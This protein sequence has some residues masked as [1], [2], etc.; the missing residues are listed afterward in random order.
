MFIKRLVLRNI[1]SYSKAEIF[2][3][4]GITLLSGDIGS[5][6]T[7]ILIAL[8]FALFGIL[9]GKTSPAELLRHGSTEGSVSLECELAGK[10]V[11]I[12]RE[13]K[14]RG[15]S[16]LQVPGKLL[17][18]GFE[19]QLV[20]TELK[21]KIL[22]FLGYPDSVL[23]KSTNLF[24]YTV[25]T[26][27]EQ[28]KQILLEDVEERKDIIRKIFNIDKYKQISENAYA[29]QNEV[30]IRTGLME[31]T[32]DDLKIL[33]EQ[34]SSQN[35]ELEIIENKIPLLE[36][37]SEK[38]LSQIKLLE[39]DLESLFK[40]REEKK[41]LELEERDIK[42][43]ISLEQNI[44]SEREQRL[45][46]LSDEIKNLEFEI[47]SKD[48]EDKKPLKNILELKEQEDRIRLNLDKIKKNISL[49]NK[50]LGGLDAQKK[51]SVNSVQDLTI[52]PTCK[53]VV[54]VEHKEKIKRLEEENLKQ[55]TSQ[56]VK[57]EEMK[58]SFQEKE[59]VY[60]DRLNNLRREEQVLLLFEQEK[61]SLEEKKSRLEKLL[62]EF[63]EQ[64]INLR[65]HKD[66]I[67]KIQD[68][69]LLIQ[70]RLSSFSKDDSKEQ[71]DLLLEKKDLEK[72]LEKQLIE[73]KAKKTY[74]LEKKNLLEKEIKRKEET[75]QE[76]IKLNN[77]RN[78]INELF[79]PLLKMI[80]KKVLFK[81][82]KEFHDYFS[83]WFTMLIGS[84]D[85]IVRLDE[86]FTPLITQQGFD[87]NINNL[88]GGE[89]TAVALA[90]RLALNKVLNDY[91][92]TLNTKGLLILDE[93][94]DGFSSE[95]ID[96]LRNVLEQL[97]LK[98]LI[99]VSHEQRLESLANSV[100]RISKEN[101]NSFLINN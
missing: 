25:Y 89:K 62:K 66:S 10:E 29:Y 2:F 90:Y 35:K 53:Q 26:P 6:K 27:Q 15:S 22:N 52:C 81:V 46:K 77:I 78:W 93:P 56:E 37:E 57:L 12:T 5:G 45:K 9:R 100:I 14:R 76:V 98:Q 1:R 48:S 59:I 38:L 65:K 91:F 43:N 74:L 17:V 16:I 21:A 86:N 34:L 83:K 7:T 80:E 94:T 67:A 39:K 70:K 60:E 101:H 68:D 41:L 97:N 75:K 23:S 40:M 50:K 82:Y 69:L 18:D 31:K 85:L 58:R 49:L 87:T 42:K 71:E 11:I 61:K 54:G 24:R 79:I 99:I 51:Q 20:A 19:E 55:L 36:T 13:L 28:V 30:R 88:S 92:G 3:D 84:E 64:E 95:Q 44:I 63:S 73:L 33:Q 47:K 32:F 8:E 72:K 96:M 4:E